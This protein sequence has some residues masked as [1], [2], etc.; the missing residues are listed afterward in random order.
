M[1]L[2]NRCNTAVYFDAYQ[3]RT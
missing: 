2:E 3:K 1:L